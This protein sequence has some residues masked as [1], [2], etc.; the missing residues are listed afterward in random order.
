MESKIEIWEKGIDK[1]KIN[2]I[3]SDLL[4]YVNDRGLTYEFISELLKYELQLSIKPKYRASLQIIK[5]LKEIKREKKSDHKKFNK[6]YLKNFNERKEE[7]KENV[8]YTFPL[9]IKIDTELTYDL[10]FLGEKVKIMQIKNDNI[11]ERINDVP[12]VSNEYYNFKNYYNDKTNY[13]LKVFKNMVYSKSNLKDLD[14]FFYVFKGLLEFTFGFLDSRILS[15]YE[16]PRATIIFPSWVIEERKEKLN[17]YD[18]QTD[19]KD[20]EKQYKT[21]ANNIDIF[22]KNCLRLGNIPKN[23]SIEELLSICLRMY[24][25]AREAKY[26]EWAFLGYW[27]IA[28][29]ITLVARFGGKTEKVVN[30]LKIFSKY[31]IKSDIEFT[32][33]LKEIA[34]KRNDLVHIG[35]TDI[36]EWI[37]TILKYYCDIGLW[38]LLAHKNELETIDNLEKYYSMVMENDKN[39]DRTMNVIK[40]IKEKRKK[41]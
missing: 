35:L 29:T 39:L 40:F 23:N 11:I 24:A 12:K 2:K 33:I 38:W 34:K 32:V 9:N 4:K 19:H 6:I 41:T 25:T 7:K 30:R 14:S 8:I 28:E 13:V 26:S 17:F 18:I 37:I 21:N 3:I 5:T 1:K 27:Q 10:L 20:K 31:L 15:S 22:L 36:E 16:H